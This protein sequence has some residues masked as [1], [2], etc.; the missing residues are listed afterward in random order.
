MNIPGQEE[1]GRQVKDGH[2]WTLI[3]GAKGV[4]K[5]YLCHRLS[6]HYGR[7]SVLLECRE[8]LARFGRFVGHVELLLEQRFAA[9]TVSI[10]ILDDYDALMNDMRG[11]Y[12]WQL[13]LRTSR[14]KRVIMVGTEPK[15]DAVAEQLFPLRLQLRVTSPEQR[16]AIAASIAQE[17]KVQAPEAF[18][19]ACAGKF[20]LTPQDMLELI[21]Q[22]NVDSVVW[23]DVMKG[24]QPRMLTE[25][26][27]SMSPN[28][29]LETLFGLDV[30]IARLRASLEDPLLHRH[31]YKQLGLSTPKGIVLH[32]P[33]GSGKTHLALAMLQSVQCTTA[34]NYVAID[35]CVLRSKLVGDTEK[36]LARVF[37]AARDC[38]P[39]VLLFDRLE[40]LMA[41]R[42]TNAG[43][44]N[45]DAPSHSFSRLVS[46]FLTEL[47]GLESKLRGDS[48]VIVMGTVE[49]LG[50]LDPAIVRPGRLGVHIAL[51]KAMDPN[52]RKAMLD[53]YCAK[54][55]VRLDEEQR[56]SVVERTEH[57][58]GAQFRQ[59]LVDADFVASQRKQKTC[60]DYE[61]FFQIPRDS[62]P[63]AS[64]L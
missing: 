16:Q 10:I 64:F 1:L 14:G 23:N 19:V 4:G 26:T 52:A 62:A 30:Q 24:F 50:A 55:A 58:S 63:L 51:P 34:L 36:R 11:H 9:P 17:H 6:E 13:L 3:Q 29:R 37:Q 18:A 60:I 22:F 46:C 53:Y 56:Q 57:F 32:G 8:L 59:C 49:D 35:T 41:K 28:F 20:G 2:E 33:T 5:T 47:D 12:L 54:Y 25:F 7:K 21:H 27:L 45:A 40:L 15:D 42:Y 44:D 31:L 39:C 43:D 38:A 61:D 48:Q